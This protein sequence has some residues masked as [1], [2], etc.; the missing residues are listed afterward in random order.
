[1]ANN[2]QLHNRETSI[3]EYKKIVFPCLTKLDPKINSP[4]SAV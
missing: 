4:M 3:K 1:M 2:T